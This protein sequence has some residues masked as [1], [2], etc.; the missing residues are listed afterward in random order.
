MK[1]GLCPLS[2]IPVRKEADLTSEFGS[3]LL[4]GETFEI[5]ERHNVLLR[6]R[7]AYDDYFGWIDS[8]QV[9]PITEAAFRALETA[10]PVLA[11][12]VTSHA[13]S[14]ARRVALP[15]G[16]RL[17]DY[18]NGRFTIGR[19]KF[20][21]RGEVLD[22][23]SLSP[24]IEAILGHALRYLDTPYMWGGR[25]PFG[26]DCSG[27]VQM[28]FKPFGIRLRRDSHEQRQQGEPVEFADRRPGDLAFFESAR[29]GSSHVGM[30]TPGGILHAC[31][32]VRTDGLDERG[33]FTRKG[34]EYSHWLHALRRPADILDVRMDPTR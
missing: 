6:V 33:I 15:L 16:S 7:M 23:S 24:E 1:H 9:R 25:S 30:V 3:Q 4:F 19:E 21:H 10:P 5:V 26:I 18:R 27:L 20:R 13:E 11:A 28:I 2:C 29:D 31:S 32:Y 22:T 34:E 12:E 17:P 8:R 14:P